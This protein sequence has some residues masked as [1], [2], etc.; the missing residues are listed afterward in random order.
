VV[1]AGEAVALA[2]EDPL[3]VAVGTVAEGAVLD[4]DGRADALALEAPGDLDGRI[5]DGF[6]HAAEEQLRVLRGLQARVEDRPGRGG[7]DVHAVAAL[8]ER[9]RDRCEALEEGARGLVQAERNAPV[10]HG[11]HRGGEVDDGVVEE[12]HGAVPRRSPGAEFDGPGDLLQG[13]HRYR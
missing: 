9:R 3:P 5:V 8:D 11:R 13:L 2:R 6:A 7:N 1:E 4:S 12:R 10:A